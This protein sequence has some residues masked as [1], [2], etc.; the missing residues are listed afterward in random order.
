MAAKV[1][2][3]NLDLAKVYREE[4]GKKKFLRGLAWGDPVRVRKETADA[5]EIEF[6]GAP[7]FIPKRKDGGDVLVDR[8]DSRVLKVDFVDVQQGD[9]SII[10]TPAGKVILVDGGDNQ[11]FA[12]YL[13]ARYRGSTD[14]RPKEIDCILVT[15][16]DAD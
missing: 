13:A 9:G 16:G 12:R 10:E 4:N 3:I 14:A 6:D 2:Y 11:L 1:R 7:A 15:H 8:K 5:V